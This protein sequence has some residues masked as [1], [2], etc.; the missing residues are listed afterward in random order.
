MTDK[1]REKV[2]PTTGEITKDDEQIRP[3]AEMLTVFDSGAA[4]AEA[5]RGLHDLVAAVQALGKKGGLTIAVD[6]VPMKGTSD[7]V[8]V[9]AQVNVKLPKGDPASR[10]FFVDN[11]GNLVRNDPRQLAFEG[12]RVIEPQPAR[13]VN[14]EN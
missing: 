4:H 9:T 8:V 10:M 14:L 13:T 1:P 7:Q 12:M 3:F 11:A 6:V 5:S 2:D